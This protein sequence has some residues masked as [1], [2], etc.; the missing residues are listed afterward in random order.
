MAKGR[1]QRAKLAPTRCRCGWRFP[2]IALHYGS[3]DPANHP[4]PRAQIT[5]PCGLT[6]WWT[7]DGRKIVF[8]EVTQ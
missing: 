1:G 2:V 7:S 3:V 5:C 6:Y 4:E 8:E